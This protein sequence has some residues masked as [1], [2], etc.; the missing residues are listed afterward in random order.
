MILLE[1]PIF[2][3]KGMWT[4]TIRPT[5]LALTSTDPGPDLCTLCPDPCTLH[6]D[7]WT[8]CLWCFPN[9]CKH[10]TC[11]GGGCHQLQLALVVLFHSATSADSPLTHVVVSPSATCTGGAF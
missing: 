9:W 6:P 8:L 10:S 4:L 11:T 7:L 5:N 3:L 2:G 1:V